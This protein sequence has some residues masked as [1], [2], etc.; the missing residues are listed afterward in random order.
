MKEAFVSRF[1]RLAPCFSEK[2][3]VALALLSSVFLAGCGDDGQG[4][5]N[6]GTRGNIVLAN[7]NNYSTNSSLTIPTIETASAVDLDICWPDVVEDLQCHEVDPLADIDNVSFLRLSQLTEDQIEEKL[8]A[9]QLTQ[10]QVSGYL[11]YHTDHQSTCAKLS[12]L[13]LG[14]TKIKVEAEY[15]ASADTVYLLILSKGIDPGVGAR[16]MTFVKPSE[17]SSNTEVSA[18][19]GCG[20]LDFQADLSSAAVLSVPTQK[21]WVVDWQD[22]TRDG[23]GN[24]IDYQTIDGLMVGFFEGRTVAELEAEIFDIELTASSLWDIPLAGG[25]KADLAVAR[26][27]TSKE[28]FAGFD[29]SDGVWLLA[30][31]CS[32]CQ[33]PQPVVLAV[34]EPSTGPL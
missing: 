4:P 10:S 17:S 33:N 6:Q 25:R 23:Q 20:M 34:L 11:D 8:T 27:R 9:G 28:P 5:K 21:P 13:S 31:L 14:G 24:L 19:S 32:E 16:T 29:R 30:L 3:G 12:S 26:E 22:V 7:A 1:A 18:S 2:S 15:V